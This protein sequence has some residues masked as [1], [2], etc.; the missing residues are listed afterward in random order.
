MLKLNHYALAKS[1]WNTHL[2]Y[3]E[4]LDDFC[5]NYFGPAAAPMKKYYEALDKAIEK[6]NGCFF[7]GNRAQFE[8]I[9]TP[10]LLRELK[11]DLNEA[12]KLV[13]ADAQD[14]GRISAEAGHYRTYVK[15]TTGKTDVDEQA[16]K[17][18]I[19]NAGFEEGDKDWFLDVQSGKYELVIDKTQSHEGRASAKV[20][21][22]EPGRAM[23]WSRAAPK[24]GIGKKCYFSIWVKAEGKPAGT[25]IA[26]LHQGPTHV[27]GKLLYL[28]A[29]AEGKWRKYIVP[30][31]TTIEDTVPI[32]LMS[33]GKGTIWFD[34]LVLRTLP[35]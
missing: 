4:I 25:T 18:L 26:W 22:V 33:D 10:G 16:G 9:L 27:T 24:I 7:R 29:D 21:C 6:L 31:L 30:D 14:V 34:D 13:A 20:V 32:S 5:Q 28:D 15:A 1:G 19:S 3:P 12:G 2:T 23:L 17:N 11:N 8:E 35:D